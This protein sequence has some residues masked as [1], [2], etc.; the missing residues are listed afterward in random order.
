MSK[1]KNKTSARDK[2]K[3]KEWYSKPEN[4]QK[5][6]EYMK[7]YYS[8]NRDNLLIYQKE[9][10][11][12]YKRPLK[13]IV[14]DNLIKEINNYEIKS[15]LT[16]ESPKFLFSKLVPEKKVIVFEHNKKTYKNMLKSKPKNVKLFEGD[17]SESVDLNINIDMIYL[18]FN[19]NWS[20]S[21]ETI[22]TMKEIINNS[23]LFA[24]TITTRDNQNHPTGDYQFYYVSELQKLLGNLKVLYGE[25]YKDSSNMVTILFEVIK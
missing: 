17:I 15:I 16:L 3:F 23:K 5:M 6:K 20:G 14:R 4:K 7:K 13:T 24:L 18:D 1:K 8:K 12:N 9:I 10:R 22:H 11:N 2:Q 25:A 19:T 21:K